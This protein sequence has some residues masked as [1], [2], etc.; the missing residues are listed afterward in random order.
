MRKYKVNVNGINYEIE[1]EELS[2]AS[3][4]APVRAA[5]PAPVVPK[6]ASHI[7]VAPK[8]AAPAAPAAGEKQIT[9]PMPGNVLAVKVCDQQPVKK[10]EVLVLLEAMKME[11][12]ILAPCDG[13]V[14]SIHVSA[15]ATVTSGTLLC[16]IQ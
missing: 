2:A 4:A 11:N 16:V 10:G 15:G 3:P 12:E 5:A 9:A 7:H 13:I 8:T 6:A 1:I 14:D